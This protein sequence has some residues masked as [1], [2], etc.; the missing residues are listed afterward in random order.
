MPK[1]G[2]VKCDGEVMAKAAAA[3][4]YSVTLEE[5]ERLTASV[6]EL[7]PDEMVAAGGSAGRGNPISE[8]KIFQSESPAPETARA[9]DLPPPG[10]CRVRS[11]S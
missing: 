7:D 10:G 11:M 9:F 1:P 6:Q 3:L 8:F 2:G 5:L 4:G